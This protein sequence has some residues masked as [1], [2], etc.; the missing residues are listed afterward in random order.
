MG[1]SWELTRRE[2]L[3]HDLTYP[4]FAPRFTRTQSH[5]AAHKNELCDSHAFPVARAIAG[6]W[7]RSIEGT[8]SPDTAINRLTYASPQHRIGICAVIS[9]ALGDL[10]FLFPFVVSMARRRFLKNEFFVRP[11]VVL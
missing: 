3:S 1:K 7:T 9:P 5:A 4:R 10:C 6:G 8:A 11:I 2:R